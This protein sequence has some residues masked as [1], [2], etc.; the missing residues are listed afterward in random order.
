MCKLYLRGWLIYA[1]V[2]GVLVM[3]WSIPAVPPP[4]PPANHRCISIFF[5][6]GKFL[7]LGTKEEDKCP[8]SRIVRPQA[9]LQQ[10]SFIAR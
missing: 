9:T 10:F 4:S 3:H 7:G 6:D 5:L 8:A 2:Y 1:G